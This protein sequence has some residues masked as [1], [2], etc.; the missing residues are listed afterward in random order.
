MNIKTQADFTAALDN[1]PYAWPGGYPMFFVCRD[2]AAL[3]YQAAADHKHMIIEAIKYGIAA[4]WRV[5]GFEINWEDAN[6]YCDHTGKR[7]ESAYA[8]EDAA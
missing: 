6:L 2:G 4:D 8:E 1:G 5:I 7:I 3:S